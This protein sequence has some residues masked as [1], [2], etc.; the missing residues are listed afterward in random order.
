MHP[1]DCAFWVACSAAGRQQW[2]CQNVNAFLPTGQ[3]QEEV[4][5]TEMGVGGWLSSTAAATRSK[6][7]K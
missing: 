7:G 1:E 6:F 4:I 3:G 2:L 5:E